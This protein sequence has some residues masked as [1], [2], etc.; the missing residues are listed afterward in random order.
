[1]RTK[2]SISAEI[3]KACSVTMSSYDRH[4]LHDTMW[5]TTNEKAP[6]LADDLLTLYRQ[7]VSWLLDP[8]SSGY[9]I[10]TVLGAVRYAAYNMVVASSCPHSS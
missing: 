7:I 9:G 8:L 4:F 1:M 6:N 2:T 5:N 3:D 10:R